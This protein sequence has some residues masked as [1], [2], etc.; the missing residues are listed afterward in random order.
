MRVGEEIFSISRCH[1]NNYNNV[2]ISLRVCIAC[3]VYD[4]EVDIEED[5]D[6]GV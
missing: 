4:K 5:R 3:V 6:A 1:Q 2:D